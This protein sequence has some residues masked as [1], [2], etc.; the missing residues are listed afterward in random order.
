[1]PTTLR[2]AILI[3]GGLAV[4]SGFIYVAVTPRDQVPPHGRDLY[5][6]YCASCHGVAGKGDGPA[7]GALQ[8]PPIDL[9]GVRERYGSS[10][11]IRQIMSA[12][13]GRYPVRAHGDSAMPV[14]GVVFERELEE[15]QVRSPRQT[16]LHQARVISEYVLSLQE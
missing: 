1:M 13:D 10:Y 4:V 11:P 7:S 14:W 3:L 16:A 12:I 9:T 6:R 8:P 2:T 5:L 15:Q